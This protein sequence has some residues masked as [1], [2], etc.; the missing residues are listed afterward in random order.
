MPRRAV[1]VDFRRSGINRI[2][3]PHKMK[4]H[5]AFGSIV[6]KPDPADAECRTSQSSRKSVPQNVGIAPA[7]RVGR[8]NFITA[9]PT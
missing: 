5:A 6:G 2:A 4:P 1:L 9:R 8:G 7:I 3:I